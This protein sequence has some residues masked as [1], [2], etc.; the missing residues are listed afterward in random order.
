MWKAPICSGT[1]GSIYPPVPVKLVE[2]LLFWDIRLGRWPKSGPDKKEPKGVPFGPEFSR[3]HFL[4]FLLVKTLKNE[5]PKNGALK[6]SIMQW[7]SCPHVSI[8]S[9]QKRVDF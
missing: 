4:S 8:E 3:L 5:V 2:T 7:S 6:S 1:P 9:G